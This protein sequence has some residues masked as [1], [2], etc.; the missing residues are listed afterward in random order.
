MLPR[1]ALPER[2]TARAERSRASRP[3]SWPGGSARGS[4]AARRRAPQGPGGGARPAVPG[5]RCSTSSRRPASATPCSA[6]A[7]G[8]SRSRRRSARA[9]LRCALR[10]SREDEPLGTGGRAAPG[11]PAARRATA[12]GHERRQLLRRR[13]RASSS[14]RTARSAGR[15]RCSWPRSPTPGAT[16]ASSVDAAGGL[17]LRGEAGRGPRAGST[18][19]STSWAR[20]AGARSPRGAPL[21]L[22]RDVFPAWVGRGPL[23][24]RTRGRFLDIGTPESYAAAVRFFGRRPGPAA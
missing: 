1:G 14:R 5:L 19:E 3:R 9:R 21:S 13:P 2:V 22:E 15:A 7:G 20:A 10:Y 8:R 6:P 17:P 23:R 4:R 16:G 24:L 11:A 12:A 18:P